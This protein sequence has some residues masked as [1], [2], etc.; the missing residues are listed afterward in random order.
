MFLIPLNTHSKSIKFL[1]RNSIYEINYDNDF[2]IAYK[3]KKEIFSKRSSSNGKDG[4]IVQDFNFDGVPD[5]AVLRDSGVEKYYDVFLFDKKNANFLLNDQI[6]QL[7]CP[8]VDKKTK[9]ILSTC[10]HANA[11]ESWIDT[12]SIS[13]DKIVHIKR[14]GI[15]CD[16]STGTEYRYYQKYKNGKILKSVYE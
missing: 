6:S 4:V 11:C 9:H 12:Y 13:L 16:P 2:L 15:S 8:Q 3:D 5:F 1:V 10:N 14:N 7:A